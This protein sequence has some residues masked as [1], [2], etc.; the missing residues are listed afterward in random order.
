MSSSS[1]QV[2]ELNSA[3]IGVRDW[4]RQ[5]LGKSQN[6]FLGV[7]VQSG[8][9]FICFH[10]RFVFLI[11]L[12][13]PEIGPSIKNKN[14]N[15]TSVDF[16]LKRWRCF[17]WPNLFFLF[18]F[19]NIIP[20]PKGTNSVLCLGFMNTGW[21]GLIK[22]TFQKQ[23]Q[24]LTQNFHCLFLSHSCAAPTTPFITSLSQAKCWFGQF[25]VWV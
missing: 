21:R 17:C 13:L 3:P 11:A 25:P 12:W 7:S 24:S 1:Y 6:S 4:G 14:K 22:N 10:N 16:C 8:P 15:K 23:P 5:G 19:F 2:L 9:F 20:V 18:L